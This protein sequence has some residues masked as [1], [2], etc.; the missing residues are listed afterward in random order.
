MPSQ[1]PLGTCH[2]LAHWWPCPIFSFTSQA[3][4]SHPIV[5]PNDNGTSQLANDPS[6]TKRESFF[7]Q[8]AKALR[9]K[10]IIEIPVHLKDGTSVFV[11]YS[12]DFKSKLQ[13]HLLSNAF[14][15]LNELDLPDPSNPWSSQV[16]G[17]VDFSSFT[18][19][20][21]FHLTSMQLWDKLQSGRYLLHPL[22]LYI[23]KTGVDKQQKFTLE[24]LAATSSILSAASK[25][26]ESQQLVCDWLRTQPTRQLLQCKQAFG[27]PCSVN[28]RLSQVPISSPQAIA[29]FAARATQNVSQERSSKKHA[30]LDNPSKEQGCNN[31]C[32]GLSVFEDINQITV[33]LLQYI[34]G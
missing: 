15:D 1:G 31:H 34:P 29:A 14:S 13:D 24:P 20:H 10:G 3:T 5:T 6:I 8:A 7:C 19:S 30:T 23:D 4:C 33:E 21:W 27:R 2:V 32:T 25:Q 16:A 12:L 11:Y 26:K 17:P 9:H 28:E 22:T 18:H